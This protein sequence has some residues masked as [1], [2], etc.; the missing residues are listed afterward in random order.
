MIRF[1]E[2]YYANN[3]N[4]DLDEEMKDIECQCKG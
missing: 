1:Y 3:E 2:M 4:D